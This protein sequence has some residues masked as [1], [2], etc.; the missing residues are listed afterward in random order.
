MD[1]SNCENKI[2]LLPSYKNV[3]EHVLVHFMASYGSVRKEKSPGECRIKLNKDGSSLT[4]Y[5][6]M[7]AEFF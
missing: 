4:M 3:L 2:I 6:L 1:Q 5:T 7:H